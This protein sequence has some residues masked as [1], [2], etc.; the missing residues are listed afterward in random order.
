MLVGTSQNVLPSGITPGHHHGPS[1]C[2]SWS[3]SAQKYIVSLHATSAMRHRKG[4]GKY[5]A[6][7]TAYTLFCMFLFKQYRSVFLTSTFSRLYFPTS[8]S[9]M[10]SIHLIGECCLIVGDSVPCRQ[11]NEAF[12]STSTE[13]VEPLY[14][15]AICQNSCSTCQRQI[16]DC[17][18]TSLWEVLLMVVF[19]NI[20]DR[21]FTD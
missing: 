8:T 16:A 5:S 12:R 15:C 21:T 9:W 11:C 3:A 1:P 10:L 19:V 20:G 4:W 17:R 18:A 7:A 13:Y 2:R 14:I 6:I